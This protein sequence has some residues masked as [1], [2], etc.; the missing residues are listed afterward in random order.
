MPLVPPTNSVGDLRFRLPQEL[1]P[2]TGM[3]NASTFGYPCPQQALPPFNLSALP[4]ETA[5]FIQS[6]NNFSGTTAGAT[7]SEDCTETVHLCLLANAPH[8]TTMTQV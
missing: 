8:L 4:K 5:A 1:G 7:D 6:L 3:H 2:Y